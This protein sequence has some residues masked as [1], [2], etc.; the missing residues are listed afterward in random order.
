MPVP[1][2][3]IL[4]EMEPETE[5]VCMPLHRSSGLDTTLITYKSVATLILTYIAESRP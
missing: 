1:K 4:P 2:F 3:P 5:A